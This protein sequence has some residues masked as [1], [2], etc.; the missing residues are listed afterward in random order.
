MLRRFFVRH[1]NGVL[2]TVAVIIALIGVTV[3]FL[4]SGQPSDEVAAPE[5]EEPV[6]EEPSGEEPDPWR[7]P[8]TG[9][10]TDEP[11][12]RPA[13]LVKVSNSAEA[14]PQT[15][16]EHAD[17]VFEEL[18][19]GGITRFIAVFHSD[20]PEVIGPVR[21]ARPVDTQVVSGFGRP[22]F[23]YS[24]ARPEVLAM[25]ARTRAVAITEGAPGFF[26]DDGVYASRPVAPHNLF[27]RADQALAAVAEAG[28]LPLDDIGWVFAE[29]P[30]AVG[31]QPSA[32]ATIDI[33][34]SASYRTSWAYEPETGLYRR[35]Q[36]GVA[37][38]VTGPGRIGAANVVVVEADHYIG[39]SGFPETNVI[40]E[41]DAVVL[42]DGNRYP[43]RWSKPTATD[44]L[45]ILTADGGT[46]FPFK[47]G[48]TWIHL[49][50]QL[51]EEVTS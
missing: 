19:E 51:P 10:P 32:G 42:R 40:G 39:A 37:S 2:V 6:A 4:R 50:D 43:A 48:P 41:G 13:L 29:E 46:T 17:V 18:T 26:R 27:L 35:S 7:M 14:R 22:G 8:L 16:L 47:P 5:P 23:A 36:N 34:M 21:S 15:G 3:A 49:P 38:E 20:L 33:A 30:A 9:V 45:L 24:G 44:P 1:R 31:A 28:A 25:L 12:D 11:L